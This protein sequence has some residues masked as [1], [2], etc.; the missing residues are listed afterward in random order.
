MAGQVVPESQPRHTLTDE[1][2]PLGDK[3]TRRVERAS[4]D[5]DLAGVNRSLVNKRGSAG[6]AEFAQHLR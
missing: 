2:V 1:D 3:T 4:H 6:A 5:V